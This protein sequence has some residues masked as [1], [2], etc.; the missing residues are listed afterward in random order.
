[1]PTEL[2]VSCAGD[3]ATVGGPVA[4]VTPVPSILFK[5][6]W[7]LESFFCSGKDSLAL[8]PS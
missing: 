5:W 4:V 1:M 2:C 3:L 7:E 6:L 8:W